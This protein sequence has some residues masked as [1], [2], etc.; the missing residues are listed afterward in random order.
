MARV[1]V[2]MRL[3]PE[4]ATLEEVRRLLGLAAEEVDPA[5]GVVNIS[6]AEHLYTILVDQDAAARIADAPQVE[7]VFSNPRIEP[8]G[9]PEE[10]Q[11]SG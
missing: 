6:P 5:F 11:S 3:A 1:M 2:T 4:Q 9:P 7:G 8:F 10:D